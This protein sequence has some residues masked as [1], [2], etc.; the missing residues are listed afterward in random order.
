MSKITLTSQ[1]T[2]DFGLRHKKGRDVRKCD[3]IKTVL[4]KPEDLPVI[5]YC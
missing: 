5:S 3:S 4:L 1:K 2:T